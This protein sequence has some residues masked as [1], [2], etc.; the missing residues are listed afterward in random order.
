MRNLI[1]VLGA[2]VA[3]TAGCSHLQEGKVET[4]EVARTEQAA[5]V[6]SADLMPA[7]PASRQLF[8]DV[9]ELGPGNVT[10]QAVAGAH[11]KDLAVQAKYGVELKAYWLDEKAGKIYCLAEAPSAAALNEMH[12]EAHGLLA[13]KIS[14]VT[15]DNDNWQPTP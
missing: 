14:E 15:A 8:M 11:Q 3:S 9:H 10:A 6:E 5:R 7:T 12:R 4:P 1:M 2:L 13:N